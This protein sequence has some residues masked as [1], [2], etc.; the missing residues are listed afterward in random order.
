[1][2]QAAH[3]A[4]PRVGQARRDVQQQLQSFLV[5]FDRQRLGGLAELFAER[6]FKR[7]QFQLARF[8]LGEV[9]DVVQQA[10]QRVG[11]AFHGLQVTALRLAQLRVQ[12]Q[13]GHAHDGVHR[14][15]DFVTHVR[16]ELTLGLVGRFRGVLGL[17]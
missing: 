3:I 11:R 15:S 16:Q 14:C 8:N 4:P 12:R 10:Q 9:K 17:S 1:M 13:V 7:L 6:K 5:R 2:L